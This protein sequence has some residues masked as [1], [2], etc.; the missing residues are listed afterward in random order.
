MNRIKLPPMIIY[1]FIIFLFQFNPLFSQIKIFSEDIKSE[2]G[3]LIVTEDDTV[4]DVIV[5]LG[6]PGENQVWY[7]TQPFPAIIMRQLIVHPDSGAFHTSFPEADFANHFV[8]RVGNF[9]HSNYLDEIYGDMFT[10]HDITHD[11]LMLLGL[12]IKKSEAKTDNFLGTF[13]GSIQIKPAMLMYPFPLHY[14]K[15]WKSVFEATVK[16]D[17]V[18]FGFPTTATL[19][20]WDSSYHVVDG[21]GKLILP[22]DEYEC[23]RIKTY[24][25]I[26]E[27]IFIHQFLLR[28]RKMWTIQ[29]SWLSK[30]CGLVAR[31]ISH[32]GASDPD[33]NDNFKR[34]KQVSR[35]RYFNPKIELSMPDT[36]GRRLINLPVYIS[37]CTDLNI[38][39][40]DFQIT[41]DNNVIR[42][43]KVYNNVKGLITEDWD[44]PEYLIDAG[45]VRI[46]MKG[47][48]P[49]N[50]AG[51]ICYIRFSISPG[52]KANLT[53]DLIF[54]DV[55]V[56]ESGPI[57][58]TKSGKLSKVL[59]VF[60]KYSDEEGT[61]E[62]SEIIPTQFALMQNFPNPFNSETVISYHL[63]EPANIQL[64]I[65]DI[66]G[67]EIRLLVSGQTSI[68]FHSI[69]WDGCDNDSQP[70]AAGIYFCVL[71][72]QSKDSR[73][74]DVKKLAVIK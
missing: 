24:N 35:L 16:V 54:E 29:Y 60:E 51:I 42:P 27:K 53:T 11:S 39:G 62:E 56:E 71:E 41:Y 66:K 33:L 64:R 2:P 72:I 67:R 50:K 34:A 4:N 17:T 5:D 26:I 22:T 19:S 1:F 14:E 52:L 59:F 45:S 74:M 23:L 21:W 55:K 36:V 6:L 9:I 68:G 25:T 13:S 58:V 48:R 28:T 40:L 44:S 70:V 73:F 65:F 61:S 37:D 10:F 15:E 38:T 63:P 49:L 8:G 18:I 7:L 12:G 46:L 47:D 31:I 32:S 30:E 43:M 69:L 3:T 57:V 20:V